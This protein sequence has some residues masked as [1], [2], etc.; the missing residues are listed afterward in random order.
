MPRFSIILS[1]ALLVFLFFFSPLVQASFGGKQPLAIYKDKIYGS[2]T[3][4]G[5]TLMIP[6]HIQQNANTELLNQSSAELKIGQT[7]V[8]AKIKKAFLFW[9]EVPLQPGRNLIPVVLDDGQENK[10]T[11][12]R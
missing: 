10:K 8:D 12:Y 6:K 1:L 3:I 11:V 7:P 9:T 4:L 2:A 5:Q